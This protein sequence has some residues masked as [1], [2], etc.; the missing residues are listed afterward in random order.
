MQEISVLFPRAERVVVARI[1]RIEKIKLE[2]CGRLHLADQGMPIDR[3]CGE[4]TSLSVRVIESAKGTGPLDFQV[5]LPWQ[6]LTMPCDNPPLPLKV[7]EQ[8]ALFIEAFN[9][10]NWAIGGESGIFRATPESLQERISSMPCERGASALALGQQF[11]EVGRLRLMN[12][13]P[14]APQEAQGKSTA[15][16]NEMTNEILDDNPTFALVEAID[17]SIRKGT[18]EDRIAA[19]DIYAG[20][21]SLERVAP[22]EAYR[23]LLI[24]LL[25]QDDFVSLHYS[26]S[27]AKL[28]KIFPSRET[29]LAYMRN[30]QRTWDPGV[31]YQLEIAAIELV[32]RRFLDLALSNFETWF[33]K[34]KDRIQFDEKGEFQPL[35]EDERVDETVAEPAQLD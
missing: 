15:D 3:R 21:I 26:T 23:A 19:F 29:V 8:V 18:R 2:E 7:G 33:A 31:K 25:D 12:E 16:P 35:S 5:L 32:D 20:L 6:W 11:A 10:F 22:N 9:G 14:H 28:L 34:N 17:V 24:K 30:A 4:V 1:E 13:I 27:L